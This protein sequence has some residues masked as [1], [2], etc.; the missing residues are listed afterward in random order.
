MKRRYNALYSWANNRRI[1]ALNA[2]CCTRDDTKAERKAYRKLCRAEELC[3]L[4]RDTIGKEP[5]F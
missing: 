4:I 1:K 2:W 5:L 3:W